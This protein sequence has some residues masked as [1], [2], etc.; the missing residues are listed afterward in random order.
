MNLKQARDNELYLSN[1]LKKWLSMPHCLSTMIQ[2][3][4]FPQLLD[5][6]RS[7]DVLFKF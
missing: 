4:V 6:L 1:E 3:Q 5:I 7:K 2:T